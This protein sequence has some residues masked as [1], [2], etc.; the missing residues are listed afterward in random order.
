MDAVDVFLEW[1]RGREREDG[2]FA[3]LLLNSVRDADFIKM[4]LLTD[5][6]SCCSLFL[7]IAF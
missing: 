2:L 1:S 5:N 3:S 4:P 7:K 6:S